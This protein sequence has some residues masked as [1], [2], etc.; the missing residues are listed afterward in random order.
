VPFDR[1]SFQ[2]CKHVRAATKYFCRVLILLA[3]ISHAGSSFAAG[4]YFQKG[5]GGVGMDASVPLDNSDQLSLA[6]INCRRVGRDIKVQLG[7]YVRASKPLSELALIANRKEAKL[8]LSVCV[9][10]RCEMREWTLLE[11]GTGDTYFTDLTISPR[12]V[13]SIRIIL[14]KETRRKEI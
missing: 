12:K 14:P 10:E 9:N 8:D 4:V 5:D 13:S 7:L 2:W 1:Q 11:S 3:S 6:M